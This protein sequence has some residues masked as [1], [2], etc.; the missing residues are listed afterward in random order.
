[1]LSPATMISAQ[2]ER[3]LMDLFPFK[4]G[5]DRQDNFRQ[6]LAFIDA[7]FQE[8]CQDYFGLHPGSIEVEPDKLRTAQTAQ[9]AINVRTLKFLEYHPDKAGWSGE[10]HAVRFI[11]TAVS[12]SLL[13][14]TWGMGEWRSK[15]LDLAKAV[16]EVLCY[17]RAIWA[18]ATKQEGRPP[19]PAYQKQLQ[20]PR[21]DPPQYD[22]SK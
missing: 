18:A 19:Q 4:D 12:D 13:R 20:L 11:V 3:L 8:Y 16:Y 7:H 5:K 6:W 1:M 22:A 14:Q 17:K 15:G 21:D 2:H 10:D 9:T